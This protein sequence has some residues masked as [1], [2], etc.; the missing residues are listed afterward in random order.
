MFLLEPLMILPATPKNSSATFNIAMN[1][2]IAN[3]MKIYPVTNPSFTILIPVSTNPVQKT[4]PNKITQSPIIV[5]G[6]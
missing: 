3:P 6:R 2:K 1:A 5:P 4:I